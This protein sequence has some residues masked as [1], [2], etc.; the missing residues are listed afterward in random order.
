MGRTPSDEFVDEPADFEIREGVVIIR[1]PNKS[2]RM[3]IPLRVFRI[4][5]AKAT[6]V[7]NEHDRRAVLR[8][9][10]PRPRSKKQEG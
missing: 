6:D 7:L 2:G 5:M 9:P 4:N 8:F 1:W 3:C 10:A